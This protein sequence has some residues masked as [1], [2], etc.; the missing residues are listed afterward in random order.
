MKR[1]NQFFIKIIFTVFLTVLSLLGSARADQPQALLIFHPEITMQ[2]MTGFG[3]G[4]NSDAYIN[5]IA[6]SQDRKLAYDLLYG[7]NSKG[8]ELNIIR[9]VVPSTAQEISKTS[10]LY[11][12]NFKY[13]WSSDVNTQKM[14]NAIGP[15]LGM[16]KPIIYVVPF[17]PPVQWKR[18]IPSY[19][20]D[21][22]NNPNP[23]WGG[24]LDPSHNQDYAEYLADFLDYYHRVLGVEIDVLSLQNEPGIAAKWPSCIWSGD[25]LKTFIK[26]LKPAIHARGL[27]TKLML[28][29]GTAWSGAWNHL[30]PALLDPNALPLVDIMASHSY[31]QKYDQARAL[32]ALAS[33]KYKLPVWMSEMSLMIPPE[34]DDT[35]MKAALRVA[36]YMHRDIYFGRASAWIYCFSIFTYKFPGTM[37]LL[38]PADKPGE[39][40]KLIIPKRFWA[41]ANYSQFVKPFWRVMKIEG[42]FDGAPLKDANTTGFI[43][44]KGDGYVIVSVNPGG[45]AIKVTYN[46][47]NWSIGKSVDSYCTSEEHNLTANVVPLMLETHS[48]T[49]TV[50]PFSI[51]TF[52]GRFIH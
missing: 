23:N 16:T 47:G 25:E 48:F 50:P 7:P 21:K 29:E 22:N 52:K 46:F 36:D 41:M 13:D 32:F 31:G 1:Y 34:Q 9:L 45:A 3:A 8:T 24:S 18:S 28:S 49:A 30:E 37:G 15:V 11:A 33:E 2:A 43:S 5:E 6:K 4:F 14:W 27:K 51:V 19:L 26:I 20:K 35:T 10:P 44:P 17:S 12:K 42:S 40:G 39:E 38:A